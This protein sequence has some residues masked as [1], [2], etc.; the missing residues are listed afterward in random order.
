MPSMPEV[1]LRGPVPGFVPELMPVAHSLLQV[2]E[3]IDTVVEGLSF[4]KMWA[5]PGGAASVGFHLKHLAGS[6]NRLLTY[7]RGENLTGAQLS[8]LEAEERADLDDQ[9]AV[10]AAVSA[11]LNRAGAGAIAGDASGD[12]GGCTAE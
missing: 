10:T 6:L 9:P 4:Q 3:E 7:A 2:R 8:A 1:W 11:R 5:T 12:A